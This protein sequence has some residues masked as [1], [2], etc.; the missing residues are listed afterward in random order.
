[1]HTTTNK[2]II[3][4][5]YILHNTCTSLLLCIE[6]AYIHDK[7]TCINVFPNL[8][9]GVGGLH[10]MPCCLIFH[11]NYYLIHFDGQEKKLHQGKHLTNLE[12]QKPTK[13][14]NKN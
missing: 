9:I 8:V 14:N 7:V 11:G 3:T 4:S 12:F 6:S 5:Q 13:P 2:A 1:M 10:L